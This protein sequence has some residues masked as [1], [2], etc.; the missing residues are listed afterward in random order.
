MQVSL[1]L[2][3]LV[4]ALLFIRTFL[5]LDT[6]S[7]GF[8]TNPLMR[9]AVLHRRE[10]PTALPEPKRAASKTSSAVCEALPSIEAAFSSNLIPISRRRRRRRGR[11]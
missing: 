6:F 4:G 7:S 3:A 5:N 2:V 10:N 9:H 8:D 1:A 11:D